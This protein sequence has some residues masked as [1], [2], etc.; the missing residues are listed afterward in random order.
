MRSCEILGRVC[1]PSPQLRANR[2][3]TGLIHSTSAAPSSSFSVSFPS[4]NSRDT[5][6]ACNVAAQ[7]ISTA[8]RIPN[9]ND[10]VLHLAGHS[11]ACVIDEYVDLTPHPA[12]R[13]L[14]PRFDR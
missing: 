7:R 11:S 2:N 14:N 10:F 5:T 12:L 3:D 6:A 1:G 4:R 8:A 13:Q 9:Q